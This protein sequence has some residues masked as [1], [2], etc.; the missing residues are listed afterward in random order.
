MRTSF[1]DLVRKTGVNYAEEYATLFNLING[2]FCDVFNESIFTG[3]EYF[4]GVPDRRNFFTICNNR[5]ES[6]PRDLRGTTRNI[7]GFNRYHGIDLRDNSGSLDC[8]LFLIEYVYSFINGLAKGADKASAFSH[9]EN[10]A[11]KHIMDHLNCLIDRVHH[12][13]VVDDCLIRLVPNDVVVTQ[14]AGHMPE[15][16]DVRTF[17]YKHRSM[18]GNLLEKKQTLKLMGDQLEPYRAELKTFNSD[19]ERCIFT[20]L[21][22]MDVRH[23]NVTPGDAKYRPYIANMSESEREKC[24]DRLYEM[25]LIAHLYLSNKDSIS[26]NRKDLEVINRPA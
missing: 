1:A 19:L 13:I 20:D 5:Y 6:L 7:V 16:L 25:M 11:L 18:K 23:N 8:L 17:M 26:Q 10:V 12:K 2:E 4:D 9:A 21:N 22:S 15:G 3:D 14:V 24:Y